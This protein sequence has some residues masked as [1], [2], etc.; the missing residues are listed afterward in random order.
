MRYI[1]HR[2]GLNY[3]VPETDQEEAELIKLLQ[4]AQHPPP[5]G[6]TRSPDALA[7]FLKQSLPCAAKPA[8]PKTPPTL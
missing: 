1:K 2:N 6:T 8:P 4:E 3:L 7:Q 5:G